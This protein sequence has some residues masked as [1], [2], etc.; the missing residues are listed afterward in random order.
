MTDSTSGR[1]S[2]DKRLVAL[3]FSRHAD[4][5][6][7]VTPVQRGMGESLLAA[8]I[9]RLG[10]RSPASVLEIG[11]GRGGFT[12]R[13]VEAFPAASVTV[14]DIAPGMAAAVRS[15]G[16]AVR[17]VVADAEEYVRRHADRH[18]LV[19]SNATAQW[20][21]DPSGT[22]RRCLELLQPDGV[23]ALSTF[24]ERTFHELREAFRMAYAEE[25]LPEKPHVLALPSVGR[26]REW[27]PDAA[28]TERDVVCRFSGV[29]EFLLSVRRA[30]ATLSVTGRTTIPR[31]VLTRMIRLYGERAGDGPVSQGV[32]VTYHLLTLV[33]GGV[34]RGEEAVRG[35]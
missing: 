11:C 14:V 30:G 23:L 20:F 1:C 21:A 6:D 26:W 34:T 22:S 3:R 24:G 17:V 9:D 10:G 27:L 7:S 5:Y 2:I 29:R 16:L 35:G 8:V 13:I 25:R 31:R 32:P 4:G 33:T 15:S 19:I 28:V 12:R 18:D